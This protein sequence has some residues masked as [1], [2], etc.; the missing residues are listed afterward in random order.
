MTALTHSLLAKPL[1][2]PLALLAVFLVPAALT[3]CSGNGESVPP[4]IISLPTGFRPEGIAISEG[5]LFV[6]SIPTGRI[7]RADP[8]TGL[9]AVVV[10]ERDGRNAIGLKVDG[11]GRIFVAGG[12]TGKAF[13]YDAATGLDIAEYTLALETTFVNDVVVTPQAAWFTDSLSPVLYRVEIS[14]GGSLGSAAT[15]LPLSGDVQFQGGTNLN[16]IAATPDGRILLVVQTNT[17]KL[18]S[19]D[20]DTGIA[21]TID[22]G[23]ESLPGGDGILL[24]G[25]TLYVVQ[26]QSD[27]LAVLSLAQDFSSAVV[28]RRVTNPAFDVPTTV[29]ASDG[30]LY[31]VNARFNRVPDPDTA[32]YTVVRIDKP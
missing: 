20:P 14:P 29:A 23:A 25:Q 15:V 9:G 2:L 16:G 5:K 13:V 7:Y 26:N 31:L 28:L 12:Q 4:D 8:G 32:E 30:S 1:F 24:Q 22:L 27:Q 6:G 10:E 19:V 11:R 18:F 3:G 21:R 17:G